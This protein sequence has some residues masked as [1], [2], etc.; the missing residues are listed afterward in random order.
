MTI[1]EPMTMITDYLLGGV[2]AWM[3]FFLF[4]GK[5]ISKKLW[6]IAIAALAVSAFLGGTHH[7]FAV[8]ALWTPTLLVVGVASFGMLAG[9]AYATTTGIIRNTLVSIAAVKLAGYWAWMLGH[10]EF[11]YV[12]VDTGS[13]IVAVAILHSLTFRNGSSKWILGGVALSLAAGGVQASG[14][15][16]HEHFNHNDLYHVIQ[17]AAMFFYYR[18]VATMQDRRRTES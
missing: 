1:H 5:E 12:V 10:A 2:T 14:L 11:I 7:G 4:K 15:A 16:L 3:A 9:S 18:G 17:I 13:A 6:A 8:E